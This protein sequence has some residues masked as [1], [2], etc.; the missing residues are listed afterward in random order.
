VRLVHGVGR[1]HGVRRYG[2]VG[3]AVL[4]GHI[5]DQHVQVDEFLGPIDYRVLRWML[6]LMVLSVVKRL[7]DDVGYHRVVSPV[8]IR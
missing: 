6:V 1:H 2:V 4:V 7:V 8:A 3:A 5:V